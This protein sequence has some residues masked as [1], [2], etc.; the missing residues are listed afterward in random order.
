[1][2]AAALEKAREAPSEV[3]GAG[4]IAAKLR[5]NYPSLRNSR[6]LSLCPNSLSL[7][8]QIPI[9]ILKTKRRRSPRR[10]PSGNAAMKIAAR[11][12]RA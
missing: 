6:R 3:A 7:R 8:S 4:S 11:E 5:S 9:R 10:N 12:P 1:M 2:Q